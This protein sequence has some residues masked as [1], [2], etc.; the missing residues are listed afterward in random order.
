MSR[1]AVGWPVAETM[2]ADDKLFINCCSKSMS[3]LLRDKTFSGRLPLNMRICGEWLS[4]AEN[5][6]GRG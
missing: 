5:V 3:C 1:H 6:D 4:L 2:T